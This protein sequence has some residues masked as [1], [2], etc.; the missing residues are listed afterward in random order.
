MRRYGKSLEGAAAA[1]ASGTADWPEVLAGLTH[2]T[3]ALRAK[4]AILACR[5]AETGRRAEALRQEL[6]EA[7]RE[8][9][10]DALTG[11]PNRRALEAALERHLAGH[12]P[13]C[14]LL[15]DVDHFKA[16]N[17]RH[18]HAAG[19]LAL[20]HLGATLREAACAADLPARLG[21][22]E[23]AVLMPANPPERAMRAAEALR[24][25]IAREGVVLEDGTR[26]AL[27]VS[28]GLAAA[29]PGEGRERLAERAD[30]ALCAAK[31]NGRNR[32][33]AAP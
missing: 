32:I 25:A 23:F 27:T 1:L 5:L 22:E 8:A 31:R 18:G 28:G 24:Q 30:A 33:E 9:A 2:E 6:E 7:R 13:P 26:L 19:D 11:L 15:L 16:V 21:G 4:G 29:A 10:T 3:Q 12:E 20:R 14:L 17:D